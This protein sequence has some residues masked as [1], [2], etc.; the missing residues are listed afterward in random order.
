MSSYGKDSA[1]ESK[2]LAKYKLFGISHHSGGLEGGHYV[3]EVQNIVERQWYLCN[4]SLVKPI[5]LPDL[6]SSSAYVLFYAMKDTN[7]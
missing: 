1:H 3:A 5:D 4:D 2:R 6:N 7:L